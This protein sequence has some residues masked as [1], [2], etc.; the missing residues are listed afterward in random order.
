MRPRISI[1]GL[2]R[3]SLGWLVGPLV[4]WLVTLLSQS[5][6]NGHLRILNDLDIAGGT[7]RKEGRRGGRNEEEGGTRR[8]EGRGGRMD[9]EKGATWRKERWG[10]RKNEKVAWGR[11]VDL[12]GLFYLQMILYLN[13]FLPTINQINQFH[14]FWDLRYEKIL[15]RIEFEIARS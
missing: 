9:A 1:R 14:T 15:M 8:K 12:R 6:K 11:I 3:P 7:R 10:D 13:I 5:M 2:V 4:R